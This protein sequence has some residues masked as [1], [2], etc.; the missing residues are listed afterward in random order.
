MNNIIMIAMAGL[1]LSGCDTFV[2]KEVLIQNQY[3]VRTATADQKVVPPYP[4][5]I[6]IM[7][8]DQIALAK[9]ISAS[10]ERTWRLESII[11][12]LVDFY[13]MPVSQAERDK[14][15]EQKAKSEKTTQ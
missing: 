8:A 12:E 11:K 2:K 14:L 7:T 10:E 5:A 13:E 9:W 4:A 3:I 1:A 15:E 6:D